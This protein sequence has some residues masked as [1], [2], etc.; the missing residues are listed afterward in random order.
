MALHRQAP[1]P[2]KG[3]ADVN[4]PMDAPAGPWREATVVEFRRATLA[5]RDQVAQL[6][7]RCSQLQPGAFMY[8]LGARFFRCYYRLLLPDPNTIVIVAEAGAGRIFGFVAGCSNARVEMARLRR[9]RWRLLGS[10]LASLL[11][12]PSL[13][14]DLST[15]MSGLD[16]PQA[17]SWCGHNQ[18]RISFWCWDPESTA[19]RQ[20]TILLQ[21]F[22]QYLKG[23]G[24]RVVRF[25]VDRINRKVEITH[26]LMGAKTVQTIQMPNGR[27][28]LV[29]EHTLDGPGR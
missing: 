1:N 7:Y 20:S 17:D 11:R 15:R 5:D 13:I 8:K 25:E 3:L 6:H 16:S 2:S 26:R 22:L 18:P 12:T 27:E 21:R 14:R 29:M 23:T 4:E 28:R 9:H 19:S 10:C 24:A